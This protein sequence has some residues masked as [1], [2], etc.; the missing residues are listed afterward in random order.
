MFRWRVGFWCGWGVA[1]L[2][3]CRRLVELGFRMLVL[4]LEVRDLVVK[5]EEV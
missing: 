4:G 5:V 1:E 2:R 3:E